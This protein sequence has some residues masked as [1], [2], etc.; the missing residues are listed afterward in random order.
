VAAQLVGAFFAAA[1]YR[2]FWVRQPI[3]ASGSIGPQRN[4]DRPR[5]NDFHRS[6]QCKQ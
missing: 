5:N 3:P 6:K 1:L 2:W 4:S